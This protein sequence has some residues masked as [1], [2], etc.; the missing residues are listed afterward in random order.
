MTVLVVLVTIQFGTLAGLTGGFVPRRC[1]PIIV[2]VLANA[3]STV[4]RIVILSRISLRARVSVFVSETSSISRIKAV[5]NIPLPKE[6]YENTAGR[7]HHYCCCR[8][9]RH[10][11]AFVLDSG[12]G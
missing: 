9:R 6:L 12:D 2:L 11:Q 3:M 8:R 4:V 1:F 10:H 7:F 5:G